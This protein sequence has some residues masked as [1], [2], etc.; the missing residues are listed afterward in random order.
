MKEVFLTKGNSKWIPFHLIFFK[1][2][3]WLILPCINYV[4]KNKVQCYGSEIIFGW[5]KWRM[6]IYFHICN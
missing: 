3:D 1:G 4:P 6:S 5:L 2:I